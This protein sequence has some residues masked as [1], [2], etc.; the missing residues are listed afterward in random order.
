MEI[1]EI[2]TK[3]ELQDIIESNS[4]SIIVC[5]FSA[6]WCGPCKQLTKIITDL[7]DIDNIIF[8][9]VDVDECDNSLVEEYQVMNIPQMVYFKQGEEVDKTVGSLTK[10]Q[11]LEKINELK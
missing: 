1:R 5:K 10:K 2:K 6:Q 9:E 7:E 4:N 8:T 11:I 3:Q